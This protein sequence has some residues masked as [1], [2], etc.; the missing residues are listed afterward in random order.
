M[1]TALTIIAGILILAGIAGCVVPAMPGP[2]LSFLGLIVMEFTSPHPYSAGLL[3]FYA[4][5]TIGVTVAD[6]ILP[7]IG[8]KRFGSSK[9]GVWGAIIGL[10]IGP[11]ILP[12]IGVLIGPFVGAV[13]G[14]IM[15]DKKKFEDAMRAGLGSFL[16]LLSGMIIKLIL[17][18]FML[19]HYVVGVIDNF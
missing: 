9:Y 18:L 15:G 8:A 16:G 13:L 14:E 7:M 10:I 12:V 5:L 1:D 3:V 17:S 6:Y 4:L 2:P 19:Y 11:F